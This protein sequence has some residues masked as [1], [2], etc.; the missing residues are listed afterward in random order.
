MNLQELCRERLARQHLLEPVAPLA[1]A[2]DLCGL[3]AQFLSYAMHALRIRATH[4]SVN[5]LI[6]SWTLRGTMH[7]F[8]ETD[9][10]LYVRR[11]GQ[12]E[13][14]IH[15]DWY[16][17]SQTHSGVN[18]PE[19]EQYF[20]HLV[21]NAIAEGTDTREALRTL[22]RDHGMTETKKHGFSTVGAASSPNWHN[23]ALSVSMYR[24]KR[25]TVSAPP[26]HRWIPMTLN[27]NWP[28]DTSPIIHL[29]PCGRSIL[30]S[31]FPNAGQ[32]LAEGIAGHLLHAGRT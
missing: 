27:L 8:P 14:V 24:R 23:P 28:D 19:R 11:C 20:A 16:L 1:A 2:Q 15:S 12:P 10:P 6:K 3:Q 5:G 21:T 18:P 31:R 32:T 26:S 9:L 30:L 25:H 22:C 17:W 29:L 13:D 7:I 4:A